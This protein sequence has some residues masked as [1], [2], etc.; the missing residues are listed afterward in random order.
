MNTNVN[1]EFYM[2]LA[3]D[4]AERAQG[5]TGINPVVGCVVVKDGA[6]VGLGTHLQR[7]TPHAEVHALNMAGAKAEGSTVYVTLE[8]CNHF[9]KTPPCS[10]RLIQ[11]KV[12]RVIVAAEDP[13]S[14]VAG[15]GI[16]KLRKHGIQVDVGLLGERANRLNE[17]F[18]K[19]ITTGLPFVT[20]KTASTLDGR[21]ATETGD[22]KWISNDAAREQVHTLRHRNQGIMVGVNTVIADN[23]QL[24]TRLTGMD[25]LHPVRIIVDSKLRIPLNSQVIRDGLSQSIVITTKDADPVKATRLREAGIEVI[26][27]GSGPHVDLRQAMSELGTREISSILLEGGGR[28][29]G[30]MLEERLV[31]R[32]MV[33]I[34]P[35]IIGGYTAPM[36]FSFKGA[37]L[38]KDAIRLESLQIEQLGDNICISGNPVW[39]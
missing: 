18:M 28:L 19:F 9:G 13:N 17:K 10:D 3:L 21:I 4:M 37:L 15:Q 35:K 27:C 33:Y 7:G 22:S 30:A 23:P 5:Q 11:E 34:A 32:I 12:Q 39:P 26:V 14:Q 25:G 6:M 16:E 29:N 31:D 36:S 20:I 2:S 24:T 8:P 1:D 38:M